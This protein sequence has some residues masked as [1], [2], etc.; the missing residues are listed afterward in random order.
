MIFRRDDDDE[1]EV[2]EIEEEVVIGGDGFN[3]IQLIQ[4]IKIKRIYKK[5]R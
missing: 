3:I 5:I 2:P 4:L 1:E